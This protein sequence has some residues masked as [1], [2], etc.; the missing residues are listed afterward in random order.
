M[1]KFL[2]HD[3]ID[4]P[5]WDACIE[6]ASNG[7]LYA[8]SW[9]L[10]IVSPAWCAL[11][12]DGYEKVFPLPV[13]S[14]AGIKYVMQP[15]FTQQLGLYHRNILKN[16]DL[17]DF[18]KHIEKNFSYVDINLNS[19]NKVSSDRNVVD[20][21]NLEIDLKNSYEKTVEGYS[22][23]LKRKLK[24]ASGNKLTVVKNV[25]PD[26][27]VALFRKNKGAD[28]PHFGKKQYSIIQRIAYESIHKGMGE[29]FG[30]YDAFNHLVAA[31]LWIT[32]HQKA[33]FL[34]SALSEK[35]KQLNAMPLLID[36]FIHDHSGMPLTLDF[37]GSSDAGLA[38]F[39]GSF[40]ATRITY[41]R[42]KY[43]SLPLPIGMAI[44]IWR[45]GRAA[46]KK[47]VHLS[48]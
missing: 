5:A 19:S 34:F 16:N 21:T 25:R 33:I 22:E 13:L 9:Y 37:E 18:L 47:V 28:L 4:K 32:S 39:Y 23:N 12:E 48:V 36:S 30:V 3:E 24:K 43:D 29:T 38:R 27:I 26:E 6:L 20:M 31:A 15:V 44:N 17:D 11:V 1:L 7:N 14:K 10:D 41:Q 2:H 40:G 46:I 35:G 45:C 42:Y 8:F